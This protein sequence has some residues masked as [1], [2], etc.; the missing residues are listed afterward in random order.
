[1]P[2]GKL[3]VPLKIV[4]L[5]MPLRLLEFAKKKGEERY[6]S[7]DAQIRTYAENGAQEDGYKRKDTPKT[8]KDT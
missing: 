7:R 8:G 1:M 4:N 6:M 5:R 2:R 3:G